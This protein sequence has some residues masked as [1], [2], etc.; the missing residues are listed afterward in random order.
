MRQAVSR[1]FS[2]RPFPQQTTKGVLASLLILLV[3]FL[4]AS[5]AENRA[6]IGEY[7]GRT[8]S[9]IEVVFEGSPPDATAQAEFTA[10][11]KVALNTEYSAVRVRDSL[12]ALFRSNRIASARVEITQAGSKSGPVRVKFII[13]RQIVV[14]DI[15]LDIGVVSG[16]PII[17]DE[18]RGRLNLIRAGARVT[19]QSVL[20]NVDE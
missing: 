16:A 20:H 2:A 5:G 9:A 10:M 13:Q 3:S 19:K 8:I 17:S 4:S 6:D 1:L 15:R 11:L 12:E 7:D 14:A 18:L